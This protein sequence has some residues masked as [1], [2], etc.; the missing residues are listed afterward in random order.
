MPSQASERV[1]EREE[2]VHCAAA[3]AV[4]AYSILKTNKVESCITFSFVEFIDNI[5]QGSGEY[6]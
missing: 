6:F 3:A 1:S 4:V 5:S 2:N